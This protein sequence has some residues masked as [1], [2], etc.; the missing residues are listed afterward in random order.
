MRRASEETE[1]ADTKDTLLAVGG[2]V[3]M[4]FGAR[5]FLSNPRVRRFLSERGTSGLGLLQAAMPYVERYVG[6]RSA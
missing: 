3:L 1:A 2:L 5:L 4:I 6:V